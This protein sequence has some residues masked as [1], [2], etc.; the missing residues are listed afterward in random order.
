MSSDAGFY[1]VI[2][3]LI[4]AICIIL[5]IYNNKLS[6]ANNN[7]L[8]ANQQLQK[9]ISSDPI[10]VS[11]LETAT[12]DLLQV[13]TQTCLAL[14]KEV[15]GNYDQATCK[16]NQD[17]AN[18]VNLLNLSTGSLVNAIITYHK[19][20]NTDPNTISAI[21]TFYEGLQTMFSVH[22]KA[23]DNFRESLL[24]DSKNLRVIFR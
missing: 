9:T 3:V 14:N 2:G 6:V 4:F 10:T 19:L 22:D 15:G 17:I 1:V 16:L 23:Y 5:Y 8:A 24:K 7:L 11:K 20:N 13:R 12:K 18:S 21:T